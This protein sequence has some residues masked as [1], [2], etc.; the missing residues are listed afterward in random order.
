M[1]GIV[2]FC[3]LS[4]S[5]SFQDPE[6]ILTKITDALIHRG[7]DQTGHWISKDKKVFLGHQR[8]SILDLS[9]NASQPMT[10]V[11]KNW[12]IVFNGE[13]Y[14]YQELAKKY[15]VPTK[16]T[17][18]D[19]VIL[20]NLIDKFGLQKAVT[21]IEGMFA[22][23]AYNNED[24]KIYL[25]RD[26]IGEKPLFYFFNKNIFIFGSEIKIFK[27]FPNLDLD[28]LKKSV[29]D[30][31]SFNYIPRGKTI[32]QQIHKVNPGEIIELDITSLEKK[33]S[34]YWSAKSNLKL[35]YNLNLD[36]VEKN[37][38]STLLEIIEKEIVA[39]VEIGCFLSS[40]IDSSLIASIASTKVNNLKTFTLKN[41]SYHFDE[42]EGASKIA[43]FLKTEH[44]TLTVSND[45]MLN[46]FDAM[47][48][49]YDEPFGDSSQIPT[50][51]IS[52][53]ASKHVKVVLSGDGADEFFGGYNRYLYFL[54]FWPIVS[55]L[56][57]FVKMEKLKLENKF[58]TEIINNFFYFLSR[59]TLG[60]FNFYNSGYHLNK[61][62]YLLKKHTLTESFYYLITNEYDKDNFFTKNFYQKEF[63]TNDNLIESIYDINLHDIN[64]YLPDD[65]LTKVDRAS[66]SNGLEVR[67]PYLNHNLVE[68]ALS[69]PMSL[70]IKNFKSKIILKN[71]LRKYIPENLVSKKKRGFSVPISEWLKNQL[72]EEL[73][74]LS[75]KSFLNE[76]GIFE[77]EYINNLINNFKKYNLPVEKFLWSFLIF[78]KWFLKNTK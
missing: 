37:V 5:N 57:S 14:N 18:S 6:K 17:S 73:S 25:A 66:M 32:Y 4:K 13:I 72:F 47:S 48:R 22:I 64:N 58:N 35:N 15:D 59:L 9:N 38:N 53:F 52:K 16:E 1:C 8:L 34:C 27:N 56:P 41:K 44:Y 29:V 2:G 21:M 20:A 40:G 33:I 26:R 62:F 74:F 10:S 31:F 19:T 70:K 24:N 77:F 28:I 46:A 42:S 3:L 68:Y 23:A 65:I 76:Q 7:P 63:L 69:I 43:N 12:T 78:Q 30:F 51:L 67:C 50:Y 11:S 36:E 39:D 45:D 75:S 71:I 60:Y 54:K 49:I 61:I 55:R